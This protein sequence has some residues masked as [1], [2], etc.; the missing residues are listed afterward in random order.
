MFKAKV[1]GGTITFTVSYTEEIRKPCKK[2]TDV[3]I[4]YFADKKPYY[5]ELIGYDLIPEDIDPQKPFK[6][7]VSIANPTIP[8]G[9][10]K[11]WFMLKWSFDGRKIENELFGAHAIEVIP[12]MLPT[13]E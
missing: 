4:Y 12:V 2:V 3:H 7:S 11:T 8:K 5:R 13:P 1:S 10:G 6:L 9:P